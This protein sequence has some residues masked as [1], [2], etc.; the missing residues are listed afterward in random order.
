MTADFLRTVHITIISLI[1]MSSI[2]PSVSAQDMAQAE[3]WRDLQR[4][5]TD[6]NVEHV[7]IFITGWQLADLCV[8]GSIVPLDACEAK[9]MNP[10]WD[11]QEFKRYLGNPAAD[12]ML[13]NHRIHFPSYP[14]NPVTYQSGESKVVYYSY[15]GEYRYIL[16]T[17]NDSDDGNNEYDAI[18]D[19]CRPDQQLDPPSLSGGFQC[20]PYYSKANTSILFHVNNGKTFFEGLFDNLRA[21]F[22]DLI[23]LESLAQIFDAKVIFQPSIPDFD[24][25]GRDFHEI[26]TRQVIEKTLTEYGIYEVP[27]LQPQRALFNQRAEHLQRLIDSI[28]QRFAAQGKEVEVTII[29]HSLGGLVATFWA[30]WAGSGGVQKDH[31]GV[32][33]IVTLDSPLGRHISFYGLSQTVLKDCQGCRFV[34]T[35]NFSPI[36][37]PKLGQIFPGARIDIDI[38]IGEILGAELAT[39]GFKLFK[40]MDDIIE[41]APSQVPIYTIRN[42]RDIF[43]TSDY[44]GFGAG[45]AW[46]NK[47]V[48]FDGERAI[49]DGVNHGQVMREQSIAK[50][51]Q[52]V[53]VSGSIYAPVKPEPF[54]FFAEGAPQQRMQI[55]MSLPAFVGSRPTASDFSVAIRPSGNLLQAAYVLDVVSAV[56]RAVSSP[57]SPKEIVAPPLTLSTVLRGQAPAGTYDLYVTYENFA[58]RTTA[59]SK[60]AV[61]IIA[62]HQFSDVS[63]V[64][65]IDR[66][67][68]MIDVI[69]TGVTKMVATK[70]AATFLTQ[71]TATSASNRM[72]VLQFNSSSSKVYPTGPLVHVNSTNVNDYLNAINRISATGGTR[73]TNALVQ[74]RAWFSE[75]NTAHRRRAIIALTDGR[76]DDSWANNFS[77]LPVFTIGFGRQTREFNEEELKRIASDTGGAYYYAPSETELRTIFDTIQRQVSGANGIV[78]LTR[79]L[80]PNS[81]QTV[82]FTVDPTIQGFTLAVNWSAVEIPDVGLSLITPDNRTIN[83]ANFATVLPGSSISRNSG[84]WV[85]NLNTSL[86]GQWRLAITGAQA[87][88]AQGLINI[89]SSSNSLVQLETASSPVKGVLE[90]PLN[91]LI[92]MT[93][94]DP[95]WKVSSLTEASASAILPSGEKVRVDLFDDGF[96]SDGGAD[97][98]LLAAVIPSQFVREAGSYILEIAVSGL[99][100]NTQSGAIFA[101][102]DGQALPFERIFTTVRQVEADPSTATIA[103]LSSMVVPVPGSPTEFCVTY[104]NHGPGSA[105]NAA[106]FVNAD[107]GIYSTSDPVATRNIAGFSFGWE[108]GHLNPGDIGVIRVSMISLEDDKPLKLNSWIADGGF[109]S[110]SVIN[111]SSDHVSA[112]NRSSSYD[113]LRSHTFDAGWTLLGF[114][115]RPTVGQPSSLFCGLDGPITVMLGFDREGLTYDPALPH[116][117]NT[118]QTVDGLHGYWVRTDAPRHLTLSGIDVPVDTP[119]ELSVGWNLVNYL[120]ETPMAISDALVSIAGEYDA[121]LGYDQGATSFYSTIPPQLN[122]L[123]T[124]APGKAY[125]IHMKRARTLVYPVL[126]TNPHHATSALAPNSPQQPAG[127]T[128]T[129]QW[130]NFLSRDL[131]VDGHP[132][133]VGTLVEAFTAEGTKI[134]EARVVSPGEMQLLTAYGDDLYTPHKDGA[135]SGDAILFKID[136]RAANPTTEHSIIWSYHGDLLEFALVVEDTAP[137]DTV[138]L[139][140]PMVQR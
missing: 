26:I 87:T 133:P 53:A 51:L 93:Q 76:S 135:I 118:L 21:A 103:N 112:D 86:P 122:T 100:E 47:I 20:L 106:L 59:I 80:S 17:I 49:S 98:L 104:A 131:R 5:T 140:L 75:D 33:A 96:H 101:A 29:G 34:H 41:R 30:G 24:V 139:Y 83:E 60:E 64:L 88:S 23:K 61:K 102:A 37:V 89:T 66:S 32:N 45:K 22:D 121:V 19:I 3:E 43:I 16:D 116:H 56:E 130:V 14:E 57:S 28:T 123:N 12:E 35:V 117:L 128:L 52:Y 124:L 55:E 1:L 95:I 8:L 115:S 111:T 132:A 99:M 125:W 68:S 120:L 138:D 77:D 105:T 110:S 94:L 82:D 70:N 90:A 109:S 84:S 119:V 2:P 42:L 13:R 108:L 48:D 114:R 44:A 136:G 25:I 69:E 58:R 63:L 126:P 4:V 134:G 85:F 79:A 92:A 54:Q 97:D 15:T 50:D 31:S 36:S 27:D 62:G 46:H 78:Q 39:K 10:T 67:G 40:G 73:L 9:M 11:W 107:N 81:T 72:G 113:K 91:T 127:V 71:L 6:N 137:G 18:G 129:N 65:V 74:A 7:I 38:P